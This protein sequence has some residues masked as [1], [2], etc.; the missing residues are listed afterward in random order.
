MKRDCFIERPAEKSS[1]AGEEVSRKVSTERVKGQ[2]RI[3]RCIKYEEKTNYMLVD[4][5]TL[6]TGTFF[7]TF[8]VMTSPVT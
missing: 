8:I 4:I 2:V 1:T 6:N 5:Y 3:W 7:I